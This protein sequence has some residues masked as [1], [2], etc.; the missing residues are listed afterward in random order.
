MLNPFLHA[1]RPHQACNLGC[2]AEDQARFEAEVAEAAAQRKER[3]A[4][5]KAARALAKLSA[6]K[7]RL[8]PSVPRCHHCWPLQ[9]GCVMQQNAPTQMPAKSAVLTRLDAC[10]ACQGKQRPGKAGAEG[11]P[12]AEV[13]P[14]LWRGHVWAMGGRPD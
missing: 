10:P 11:A 13:S 9:P 5:S 12:S 1:G 14:H 8:S 4:A 6:G 2:H 3:H 7:V